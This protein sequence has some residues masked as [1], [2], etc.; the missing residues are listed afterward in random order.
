MESN[1]LELSNQTKKWTDL[2]RDKTIAIFG[3]LIERSP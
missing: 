3:E 1:G 2:L